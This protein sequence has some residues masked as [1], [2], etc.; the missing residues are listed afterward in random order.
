MPHNSPD[1]PTFTDSKLLRGLDDMIDVLE[2]AVCD[3]RKMRSELVQEADELGLWENKCHRSKSLAV[4]RRIG[5]DDK[6]VGKFVGTAFT[7]ASAGFYKLSNH[8]AESARLPEELWVEIFW[9]C[10]VKHRKIEFF[11]EIPGTGFQMNYFGPGLD[12]IPTSIDFTGRCSSWDEILRGATKFWSFIDASWSIAA[13]KDHALRSDLTP[14]NVRWSSMTSGKNETLKSMAEWLSSKKQLIGALQV[15]WRTTWKPSHSSEEL[16]VTPH[17]VD[18]L[19]RCFQAPPPANLRSLL[20]AQDFINVDPLPIPL[21]SCRLSHLQI[22]NCWPTGPLPSSLQ[23][24]DCLTYSTGVGVQHIMQVLSECTSLRS[25]TFQLD[26]TERPFG[27]SELRDRPLQLRKLNHLRIHGLSQDHF[28]WLSQRIRLETL[29][30]LEIG[31][32]SDRSQP[33]FTLPGCF[34]DNVARAACL[35]ICAYDFVYWLEGQFDHHFTINIRGLP[36]SISAIPITDAFFPSLEHLSLNVAMNDH[37]FWLQTMHSF[38][39][40]HTLNLYGNLAAM[41]KLVAGLA[42]DAPLQCPKLR[43]LSLDVEEWRWPWF[44]LD[45]PTEEDQQLAVT[46]LDTMLEFREARGIALE[47][48][49]LSKTCYYCWDTSG[50]GRDQ[51]ARLPMYK[52]PVESSTLIVETLGEEREVRGSGS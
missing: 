13:I 45:G 50:D 46:R 4:A 47:Q 38:E 30:K 23:I 25:C 34:G 27:T 2:T 28:T 24:F 9:Q 44:S 42:S 14:L 22:L 31:I 20:L 18:V 26:S 12:E 40:L 35:E 16:E 49:W 3:M 5:D 8:Y 19:A 17:V 10:H 36:A 32:S 6:C 11:P 1:S 48:L 21:E 41:T 33:P 15:S 43:A 37:A 51:I 39:H 29:P 52:S 7:K